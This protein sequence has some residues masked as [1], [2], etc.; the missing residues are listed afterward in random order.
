MAP[1]R[2]GEPAHFA[3]GDAVLFMNFRADRA[4]Q[5]A[6]ALTAPDFTGFGRQRFPAVHLVTTTEYAGSLNCPVAFPPDT[7][8][9]SL[10]EVLADKGFTQLR[11]AETEKY[12]HV[13]FFFSGGR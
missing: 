4:R 10:G 8:Q 7:L 13:T 5:L 3:D 12:A 1:T 11:I 2:I 6:Q 9:D